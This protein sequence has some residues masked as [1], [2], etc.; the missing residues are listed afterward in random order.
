MSDIPWNAPIASIIQ[1]H[2]SQTLLAELKNVRG[3]RH[4]VSGA[5]SEALDDATF[6]W[7]SSSTVTMNEVLGIFACGRRGQTTSPLDSS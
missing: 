7:R 5:V 6:G 4:A 2:S 3:T 1:S